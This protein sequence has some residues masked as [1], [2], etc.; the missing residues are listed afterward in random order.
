MCTANAAGRLQTF[1]RAQTW[2]IYHRGM[3]K[4][5]V[6]LLVTV[7]LTTAYCSHLVF[8]NA[9]CLDWTKYRLNTSNF[10]GKKK[11]SLAFT[12]NLVL[13]EPEARS[14]KA[15]KTGITESKQRWLTTPQPTML[16]LTSHNW[17]FQ[18]AKKFYFC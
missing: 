18:V 15:R 6:L 1:V 3:R 4:I 16:S 8:M 12:V 2:R 10:W 14:K 5:I 17:K 7:K 13:L 11:K 9:D